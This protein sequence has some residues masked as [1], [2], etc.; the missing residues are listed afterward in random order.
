MSEKNPP[1]KGRV[2]EV[3]TVK[4]G[5]KGDGIA[6]IRGFPV[7]IPGSDVGEELRVKITN[8]TENFAFGEDIDREQ[9]NKSMPASPSANTYKTDYNTGE[10]R[11]E[12]VWSRSGTRSFHHNH[13]VKVGKC[14][15]C[16]GDLIRDADHDEV[17]CE[18]C[19]HVK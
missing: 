1:T 6:F 7:I 13:G 8:T 9:K 11:K 5:K 16:G 2:Y 19:G 10:P 17:Y 18:E 12:S 14:Y 3:K 15:D 4:K